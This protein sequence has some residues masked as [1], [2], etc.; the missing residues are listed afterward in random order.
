MGTK[1]TRK[2]MKF[3][4]FVYFVPFMFKKQGE[5]KC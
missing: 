3:F 4:S 2:V 1:E 5:S